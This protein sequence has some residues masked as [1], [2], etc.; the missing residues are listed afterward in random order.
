LFASGY[1][2]NSVCDKQFVCPHQTQTKSITNHSQSEEHVG[3]VSP[4]VLLSTLYVLK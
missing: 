2:T 1:V 4:R 3:G